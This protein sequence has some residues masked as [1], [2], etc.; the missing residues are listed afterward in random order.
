AS[1]IAG[2]VQE[3]PNGNYYKFT[4]HF[5]L[6]GYN[7]GS[8][9]AMR[10]EGDSMY[11]TLRNEDIVVAEPVL[12]KEYFESKEIY[13]IFHKNM[14]P[15]IKRAILDRDKKALIYLSDNMDYNEGTISSRT[16]L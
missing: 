2:F 10:V 14:R 3:Y 7:N 1:C 5:S 4:T 11:P 15:L 9:I 13:I 8:A 6:P 16:L 12:D